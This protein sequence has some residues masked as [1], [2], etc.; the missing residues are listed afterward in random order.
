MDTEYI[1]NELTLAR[2]SRMETARN[3]AVLAKEIAG[4]DYDDMVA[5]AFR[6]EGTDDYQV[7]KVVPREVMDGVKRKFNPRKYDYYVMPAERL[8]VT[9]VMSERD[10]KRRSR[11]L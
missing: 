10:A 7:L 9:D 1:K 4:Y 11:K 2:M 5:F 6:V 8:R 3:L